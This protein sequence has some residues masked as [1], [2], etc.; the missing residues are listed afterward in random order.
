MLIF[1]CDRTH[2]R[3]PENQEELLKILHSSGK[4]VIYVNFS[5]SAIA[6]NWEHGNLPAIVQAF[7]PGEQTGTALYNLLI[8]DYSKEHR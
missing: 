4:P 5:G 8:G 2:I 3:L 1:R 7:Y 6:L